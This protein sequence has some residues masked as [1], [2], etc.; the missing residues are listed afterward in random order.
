VATDQNDLYAVLGVARDA[1]PDVIRKAYRALAKKHHPDLNPGDK[2]AE[3]TFKSIQRANDI[4]SDPEKR[5]RY[6]AGEIDAQGNE[7][8]KQYYREYA[9]AGG[10]QPYSSAAGYEDLGDIFADLFGDRA[11]AGPGGARG[12]IR[13]RG[14]DAR[15]TMEVSFLEAAAGAKKRVTMPDGKSLEITIPAGQRDGQVLRLRGKG[16]PGIGGGENGDAYVE[17]HVAAH[18]LFRR[19]GA[20]IH[21]DLPIALHEAVL[22]AKVRVPTVSGAVSMTI[23]AG[24]NNGDTLRLRGK[25]LPGGPS[26]KTGDQIVTIRV[27]LPDTPDEDL[28][29]FMETWAEKHDYDPRAGMENAR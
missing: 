22:G 11:G 23:P 21:I 25:G 27:V 3:D 13:M 26:G 29:A 14:G 2:A 6:D 24:S 19:Q 4:L 1:T 18:P 15:Y 10:E 8:P 28:K 9:G 5:R 12:N 7:T 17:V 20:D 16:G